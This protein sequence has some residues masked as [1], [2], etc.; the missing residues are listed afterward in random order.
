MASLSPGRPLEG[1]V[2]S[3]MQS[4][5]GDNLSRVRVHT[6]A[7]S[8]ELATRFNARAFTVG[9]HLVFGAGEFRPGTL[10][11]DAI[12]AH[13]L[14]HVIQQREAEAN[15]PATDGQSEL[16]VEADANRAV[17]DLARE[18][19]GSLGGVLGGFAAVTGARMR[20]GL[21]LQR[22]ITIGKTEEEKT[23]EEK[24]AEVKEILSKAE[25]SYKV[26]QLALDG[27]A[28]RHAGNVAENLG[29]AN[30]A[31]TKIDDAL[32]IYTAVQDFREFANKD[33]ESDPEGF[34]RS[35]GSATAS[36][37]KVMQL[38]PVLSIYGTF[39]AESGDFFVNM[40]RALVPEERK[41]Y[42]KYKKF[43]PK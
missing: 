31:L 3:Q 18:R 30:A 11:G 32:T 33:P 25:T 8:A 37:G 36:L 29:K 5:F 43:L 42:Q 10:V 12:I 13:E 6:D 35:A 9:S 26:A 24:F 27:D 38:V 22:C 20:T 40:R 7:K 19:F 28:S 14:A 16:D 23:P 4:A 41:S 21:R 2:R 17:L 15:A 39:L 34:A 1:A